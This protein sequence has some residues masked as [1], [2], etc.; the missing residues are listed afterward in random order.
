MAEAPKKNSKLEKLIELNDELENYF[1]NTIIPQLFVDADMILRK[2]TPA[3]M[4]HFKLS[5]SDVGRHIDEVS[6]NIRFPTIIDNIHEVIESSQ[7]LEKEIQTTDKKWYQMN[8]LPYIIKKENRTNGVIITF[9]D[10]NDRIHILKGYE[11]L[12]RDYENIIHSISHDIKGPL[13]NMEGLIRILKGTLKSEQEYKQIIDMLSR[14][15]DNL[16]KTV[17]ELADIDNDSAFA[18]E[19]ERVNFEN[20]IEDAKLALRDKIEETNAQISTH[21]EEADVNFSRKNVR[22]IVYNLLSNAIK[23]SKPDSKPV[24]NIQTERSGDAILLTVSDKGI[25]IAEDK[26]ESVFDRYSRLHDTVEGTGVGLFIVKSMVESM[27]GKIKVE[28]KVGEG[29][30]FKVLFQSL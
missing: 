10:I 19:P 11:K 15:V 3:A 2:F 26:L 21:I 25:G 1:N 14:S 29:S 23:Y 8:I 24:I 16:R 18:R 4:T 13:S 5:A 7:S 17:D 27:G 22:S 12:H 20:V 9:I 30:T 28:S 6:N